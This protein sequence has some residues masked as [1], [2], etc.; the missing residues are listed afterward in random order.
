MNI[1]TYCNY[2]N[3]IMC[4]STITKKVCKLLLLNVTASFRQYLSPIVRQGPLLKHIKEL[5]ETS[6]GFVNSIDRQDR[7]Q[8]ITESLVSKSYSMGHEIAGRETLD[9]EYIMAN[10]TVCY[11]NITCV[12]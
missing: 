7:Q 10:M 11:H 3:H 9:L 6:Q 1:G 5:A 12:Y 2:S 8:L 4:I